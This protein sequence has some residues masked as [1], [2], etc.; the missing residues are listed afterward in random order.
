MI[1]LSEIVFS[2]ENVM[3][4]SRRKTTATAAEAAVWEEPI[5]NQKVETEFYSGKALQ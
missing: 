5:R 1:S 3:P 2:G 4:P